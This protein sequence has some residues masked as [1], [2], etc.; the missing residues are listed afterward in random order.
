MIEEKGKLAFKIGARVSMAVMATVAL[1]FALIITGVSYLTQVNLR[2]RDIVEKNNVKS[3]MAHAMQ[4]ALSERSLSMYFMTLT[5][6][7][8]LKD[9]EYQHFTSMGQVYVK[10]R[11]KL[12]SLASTP[13]EAAILSNINVL[14][15][16][17]QHDAA[18]IMEQLLYG[19]AYN[20]HDAIRDRV[21][22]KQKLIND[23]VVKLLELQKAQNTD[24]VAE[25]EL[26]YEHARELMLSLG[27]L[28]SVLVVV[29]TL[30]FSRKV[31]MQA[32]KLEHQ[33]FHDELTSLPNR[34]LFLERLGHAI[35]RSA[36]DNNSFAI[37]LLDLD[38]F[39]EVNDT[40]GHDMGDQLLKEVS[41]RLCEVVRSSDTVAR[42][43][44]DEF[45][46]LLEQFNLQHT[47]D[48][49][50]KLIQVLEQPFVLAAQMVDVSAS[51][52]IACFP[53]HGEDSVALLQKA[54]VAMY[55]AKRNSSGFEIYSG[56]QEK[57][58]RADLTFKSDLLQAIETDELVLYFQPKI[59]LRSSTVTSV[60]ALVRWQHPQRGFLLPDMFIPMAEQTGL[61]NQLTLWV[62][63][64]A[65]TLCGE[66]GKSGMDITVAVNISARSLLDLRLPGE[67]ARMLA[68]AKIKPSMLTLEI[69]ESAVMSDP[70]E[71][72]NALQIMD[73][74]GISLS[75]DD[76]GTG[77]SSL[78]YLSKLPVDEIKID[79]SFVLGMVEDKYAAVIVRSTIELGHNLGLKVVGEGVETQEMWNLLAEWGC[80]TAQGYLMSKP[81]PVEQLMPWL[82]ESRWRANEST[83]SQIPAVD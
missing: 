82:R 4:N 37:I 5:K 76:F 35:T 52:G 45:V 21:I 31:T 68:N 63:K 17:A 30:L 27:G 43:G 11:K 22:S 6:D 28:A 79:K 32:D 16:K 83:A 48:I 13:E 47:S 67:F 65:L 12:E 18:E 44:G 20:S 58:S 25:A 7:D 26:S 34:M 72:M 3:E 46:I 23:Q 60:E 24:A 69:T 78:A 56:S 54:D 38:R 57:S 61:I 50:E 1:M 36:R 15:D 49:A 8:F 62:L 41:R 29:I 73:K 66:L 2:M 39:K 77:Y 59:D 10:A 55:A 33:A 75:I 64:K 81:V 53:D 19:K 51:L 14:T 40:L 70:A 9:D 42:L 80:D 74:M 71:A